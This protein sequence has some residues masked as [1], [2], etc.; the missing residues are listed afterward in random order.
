MDPL[1]RKKRTIET[2]NVVSDGYDTRALRFFSESAG[3][4]VKYLRGRDICRVLDVATGTG[5]VALRIAR[6]LPGVSVTGI[7]FSPGMLSR[8]RAKAEAAELSNVRFLDM[9]MQTLDFPDGYFDAAVCAFGI[10]FVADME[11]QLRHI[12]GKI[13]RGG[14]IVISGFYE[15]SFQPQIGI[16]SDLLQ[17]Y[18]VERPPLTWKRI[19]CERDCEALLRSA[20]LREIRVNRKDLGYWL[21][22]AV[23][24]WEFI[25]NAGLRSQLNQLSSDNLAKFKEEHLREIESFVTP[26]G[27]RLNV[28]VLFSTGVK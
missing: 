14:N 11:S 20:G 16:F 9:D 22:D 6:E 12:V 23:E 7:D 13:R 2:F 4:M 24:W 15:N 5:N 27:I 17:R 1:E 26:E 18:G 25:W 28:E 19:A 21:K 10:F 8:A 3:E